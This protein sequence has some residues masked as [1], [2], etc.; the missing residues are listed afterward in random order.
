[1]SSVPVGANISWTTISEHLRGIMTA[2]KLIPGKFTYC[3]KVHYEEARG[4]NGPICGAY[5]VMG[6]SSLINLTECAVTCKLC[7]RIA[8]SRSKEGRA[9]NG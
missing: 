5:S 2:A 7:L 3:E 9:A 8:K 6:W 1:M 4:L